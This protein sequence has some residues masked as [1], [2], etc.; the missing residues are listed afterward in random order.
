MNRQTGAFDACL[1]SPTSDHYLSINCGSKSESNGCAQ[2]TSSRIRIV[3]AGTP[4]G[5]TATGM[6][7]SNVKFIA[8]KSCRLVPKHDQNKQMQ[9]LHH[10]QIAFTPVMLSKDSGHLLL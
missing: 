7:T 8:L 10:L 1:P 5:L 9:T 3:P 2:S 4:E 6:I